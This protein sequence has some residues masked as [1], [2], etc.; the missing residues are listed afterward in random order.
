MDSPR[1]MFC[2]STMNLHQ[3]KR[4]TAQGRASLYPALLQYAVRHGL[5]P[6]MGRGVQKAR[7]QRQ[8]PGAKLSLLQ[9]TA[10]PTPSIQRRILWW[11][12]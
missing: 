12:R 6:Y 7:R 8:T 1:G 4:T 5:H 2:D 10:G 9:S 3:Y 11:Q